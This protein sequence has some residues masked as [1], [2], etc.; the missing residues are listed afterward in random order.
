MSITE[1][2]DR[3]RSLDPPALN[4]LTPL[5]L[6]LSV[7][8]DVFVGQEVQKLLDLHPD[9]PREFHNV[10]GRCRSVLDRISAGSFLTFGMDPFDKQARCWIARV[11]PADLGIVDLRIT[12]PNPAIRV[13]GAF[14]D[15]DLLIL[16]TW[17]PRKG[18]DFRNEVI[19]CRQEWDKLFPLH[20]PLIGTRVED[21]V[22]KHFHVG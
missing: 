22:S 12:D 20:R 21:Y 18:L 6:N 9:I 2:I 1:R 7:R 5:R 10:A 19:R 14:A 11:S 3:L 13:F 16:L 4:F 15:C 17:A 8:R